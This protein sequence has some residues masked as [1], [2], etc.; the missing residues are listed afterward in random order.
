MNPE[1]L[2]VV[3]MGMTSPV[4]HGEGPGSYGWEEINVLRHLQKNS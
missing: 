1:D 2:S 4:S 3:R